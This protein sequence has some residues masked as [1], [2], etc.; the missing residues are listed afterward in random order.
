MNIFTHVAVF[1]EWEIAE[2]IAREQ[3]HLNLVDV[4]ILYTDGIREA[5]DINQF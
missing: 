3:G 2:F 1:H 4:V 5:F